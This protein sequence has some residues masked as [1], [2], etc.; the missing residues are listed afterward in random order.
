MIYKQIKMLEN[1]LR[2]KNHIGNKQ[3][4]RFFKLRNI[5]NIIF[6]IGAVVGVILYFISQTET[7]GILVIITA[8]FFKMAECSLRFLH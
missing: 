7:L 6:M 2:R 4:D 1:Y 3:P 8:M 5:L